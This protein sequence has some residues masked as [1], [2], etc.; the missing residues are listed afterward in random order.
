ME[1]DGKLP[2]FPEIY[3]QVPRGHQ[4]CQDCTNKGAAIDSELFDLVPPKHVMAGGLTMDD[5]SRRI[6]Q[7]VYKYVF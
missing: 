6:S 2:N 5:V 4:S 3:W 7:F 1:N